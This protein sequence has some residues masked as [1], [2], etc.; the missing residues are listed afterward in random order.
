MF[1]RFLFKKIAKGARDYFDNKVKL[2]HGGS[3]KLFTY[4]VHVI[5]NKK[6]I[7]RFFEEFGVLFAIDK[8]GNV[9]RYY[10]EGDIPKRIIATSAHVGQITNNNKYVRKITWMYV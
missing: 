1:K 7:H 2:D 6:F 9:T 3:K 4:E 8:N 10:G 5:N